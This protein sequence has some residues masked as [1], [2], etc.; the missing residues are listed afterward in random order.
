MDFVLETVFILFKTLLYRNLKASF[1]LPRPKEKIQ[2]N[3]D[4][5]QLIYCAMNGGVIKVF[6][7][8]SKKNLE[9]H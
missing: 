8:I 6:S 7:N 3:S 2:I 5:G 9:I 4:V 1:Y